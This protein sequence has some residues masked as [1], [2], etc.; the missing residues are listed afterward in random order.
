[1]ETSFNLVDYVISCWPC[2]IHPSMSVRNVG[3]GPNPYGVVSIPFM[4]CVGKGIDT[5]PQLR[6]VVLYLLSLTKL[7]K[8]CENYLLK[9]ILY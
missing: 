5:S 2:L 6:V 9:R 4:G 8:L 7:T 3:K 1:M